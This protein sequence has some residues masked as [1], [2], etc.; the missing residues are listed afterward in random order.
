MFSPLTLLALQLNQAV[1]DKFNRYKCPTYWNSTEAKLCVET[2]SR[3]LFVW[4]FLNFGIMTCVMFPCSLFILYNAFRNPE[5]YDTFHTLLFATQAV[6][7]GLMPCFSFVV[8]TKRLEI[9][10][11]V[12]SHKLL[13]LI[14][15]SF[16]SSDKYR[17]DRT[18]VTGKSKLNKMCL[19]IHQQIL[20]SGSVDFVGII[21]ILVVPTFWP[22]PILLSFVA[23]FCRIDSTYYVFSMLA[24]FCAQPSLFKGILVLLRFFLFFASMLDIS[25][26][27]RTFG[28]IGIASTE[29]LKNYV[30]RLSALSPKFQLWRA[31]QIAFQVGNMS[32]SYFLTISLGVMFLLEVFAITGSVLAVGNMPWYK[33][34]IFP[35]AMV[36][37]FV[38]MSQ[39][40]HQIIYVHRKGLKVKK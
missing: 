11:A 6:M 17:F 29:A 34:F 8:W 39:F 7:C 26:T 1:T 13:D 22:F 40:L 5:K 36:F 30:C 2:G 4:K 18:Q 20:C 12:N 15:P 16:K 19:F 32:I 38:L 21:A 24:P 35:S 31:L 10:L 27:C 9:V 33:Y 25:T 28:I 37:T 14:I 23:I 3:H